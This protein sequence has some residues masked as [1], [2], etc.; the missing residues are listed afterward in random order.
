MDRRTLLRVLGSAG[1]I[2][3]LPNLLEERT[4]AQTSVHYEVQGSGPTLIAFDRAPKRYFDRFADA[5]RVIVMDGSGQDALTADRVCADILEVADEVGA[6]RFAWYGFSWGGVVGLQLASRTNRLTALVCGGWPPLEAQ[7]RET[8]AV[9]EIEASA[10]RTFYRS[11]ANWDERAAVSKLT[12]PRMTFAG[13]KDAFVVDGY[14]IHI[15]ASITDHRDELEHMGWTVR[16]VEGF[17]HELGARP[18]VVVP[19]IREFLDPLLLRG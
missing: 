9:T 6:D 7:Y 10:A 15:G 4:R 17:G 18:D 11:I 2:G 13:T 14:P 8:L 5:Y 16:M 3:A 1:V 12:C 19:L